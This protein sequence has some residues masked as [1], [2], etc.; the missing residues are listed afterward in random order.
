VKEISVD[1]GKKKGSHKKG[2][3]GEKKPGPTSRLGT[4]FYGGKREGGAAG[5]VPFSCRRG[6]NSRIGERE[7]D[8]SSSVTSEEKK[9]MSDR[10]KES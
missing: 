9:K 3:K 7:I 8:H 6:K 4:G 10:G 1:R 5:H 2:K